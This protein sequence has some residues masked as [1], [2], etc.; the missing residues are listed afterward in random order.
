MLKYRCLVLDHDDTV[1]QTEKTMGYPHFCNTLRNIRPGQTISLTDYVQTCHKLGF[2]DMCR[3]L[4]SFTD[5]ELS[6]E[7]KD[8]K[9]YVLTHIA[10]PFPGMAEI[11]H[12][13]KTEGGILCVVSHSDSSIIARDYAAHF[14]I[15]PDAIYGFDLPKE[16]RKPSPYPLLDIMERFKLQPQ[17]LYVVDDTKLAHTMAKAVDVA[18]GFAAWS[19]EEFPAL[20]EEMTA[21]CDHTFDTTQSLYDF[22]FK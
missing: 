5:E 2:V 11:I 4:W 16:K 20:K 9:D 3:A 14:G 21:L 7:H 6:A 10:P 19:K 22:L 13:Q 12:K 1:V 18:I 8:W 17:D 15:Q